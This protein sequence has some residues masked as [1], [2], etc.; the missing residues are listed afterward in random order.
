MPESWLDKNVEGWKD[1]VEIVKARYS[2]KQVI[3]RLQLLDRG[4]VTEKLLEDIA[5]TDAIG[6]LCALGKTAPNP[7]LS[8]IKYFREDYEEHIETKL[9]CK[10]LHRKE[11]LK[12]E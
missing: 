12:K 7:V 4:R 5:E 2:P 10:R 3:D 6:S 8:T 11:K 9:S 1:Y